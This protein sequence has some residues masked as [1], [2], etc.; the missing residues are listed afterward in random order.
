MRDGAGTAFLAGLALVGV[1]EADD[2][3]VNHTKIGVKLAVGLVILVLVMANVR[4]PR[5]ADGLFY[6]IFVL[7]L[8]ERRRRRL[9]VAGPPVGASASRTGGCSR[10]QVRVDRAGTGH[11]PIPPS[12]PRHGVRRR[13][14]PGSTPRSRRARPRR[15]RGRSE[16]ARVASADSVTP[17]ASSHSRRR[18]WVRP[19][20]HRADVR[21]PVLECGLDRRAVQ[22]VVVAEHDHRVGVAEAGL[23][24]VHRGRRQ[25]LPARGR[26][27][28]GQGCRDRTLAH[29]QHVRDVGHD[30]IMPPVGWGVA[31]RRVG[32]RDEQLDPDP[33]PRERHAVRAPH[34]PARPDGRRAARRPQRAAA[35]RGRARR[36]AAARRRRR[37]LRQ[38]PRAD[39]PDR[40]ADHRAQGPPRLD[41]GDH[42]HQQG[43]G[44]DEGAGRGPGRQARPDHV[45]LDVPLRVRADPAQGDRPRSATSRTS[46]ST[47]PPTPSG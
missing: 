20:A 35:G 9:L 39:P 25:R 18:A 4:K 46:R 31:R 36:R 8:R 6:A 37:R 29:H 40:V 27:H 5:I 33:R 26:D 1:L 17:F 3:D 22:P 14:R 23:D 43:R 15:C 34:H 30:H 32:R 21:R 24:L 2:V 11:S 13:S 45:G 42:L 41:P 38:D 10:L 28:R 12:R 19:R 44:R 47:T 7:A 16:P